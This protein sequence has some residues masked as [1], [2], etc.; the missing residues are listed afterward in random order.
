MF[1]NIIGFLLDFIS[2]FISKTIGFILNPL[3]DLLVDWN[4]IST[5]YFDIFTS[6]LN[7]FVF[8]YIKFARD[9]I[10]NVTGIP[11]GLFTLFGTF[12]AFCL[13]FFLG[14]L[15]IRFVFNAVGLVRFGKATITLGKGK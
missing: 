13:I 8:K 6:F 11:V 3:F 2:G 10:I 5:D 9:V 1:S 7:D 15:T 14:T 4:I 12:L